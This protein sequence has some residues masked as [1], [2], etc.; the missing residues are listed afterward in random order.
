GASGEP[1]ATDGCSSAAKLIY[2]IDDQGALHS[3]DP[4]LL[5]SSNAFKT[6][7]TPNCAWGTDPTIPF[8]G[9]GPN[10]MAID[11]NA[12]AWVCDNAGNLFKVSTSDGSCTPTNFQAGQ[13]GFGKFAMGFSADTPSGGTDTLYVNGGASSPEANDSRGMGKID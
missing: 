13:Q 7:G 10:S 4:S 1:G 3:F 2:V 5:P 9:P 11:R 6:I 8:S 12:V